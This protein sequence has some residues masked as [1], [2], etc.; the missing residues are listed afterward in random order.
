MFNKG[1]VKETLKTPVLNKPGAPRDSPS[2]SLGPW[3][4]RPSKQDKWEWIR[5]PPSCLSP[6]TKHP[7]N[8]YINKAH[9]KCTNIK[10]YKH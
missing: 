1:R 8:G 3:G 2:P 10:S 9:K 4:L 5:P 7:G 6:W